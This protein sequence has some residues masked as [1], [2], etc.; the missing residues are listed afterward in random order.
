MVSLSANNEGSGLRAQKMRVVGEA[1]VGE[2]TSKRK[3][4]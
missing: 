3:G 4:R 1:S 2:L